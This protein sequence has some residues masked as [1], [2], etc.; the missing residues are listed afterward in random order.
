M[1]ILP[2]LH[3]TRRLVTLFWYAYVEGKTWPRV[4]QRDE[5]KVMRDFRWRSF[6]RVGKLVAL[7]HPRERYGANNYFYISLFFTYYLSPPCLLFVPNKHR[8]RLIREAERNDGVQWP[9]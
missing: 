3:M 1:L 2:A 8:R 9:Y 5:R 4:R 7:Q 6:S